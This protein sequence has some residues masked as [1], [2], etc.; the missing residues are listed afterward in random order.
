MLSRRSHMPIASSAASGH[1]CDGCIN[2]F[3]VTFSSEANIA[4]NLFFFRIFY[5]WIAERYK[6]VRVSFISLV[7]KFFWIHSGVLQLWNDDTEGCYSQN[8]NITLKWTPGKEHIKWYF[9]PKSAVLTKIL[10][11]SGVRRKLSHI[12]NFNNFFYFYKNTIKKLFCALANDGN[13]Y[14]DKLLSIPL[15]RVRL[16]LNSIKIQRTVLC[17]TFSA[18]RYR[19]TNTFA[20]TH[21][22][23]PSI[24]PW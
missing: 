20:W 13:V 14:W 10:G 8:L 6:S 17:Q 22:I 12:N 2:C 3:P 4:S 21:S 1:T 11:C 16:I 15:F 24:L 7:V 5:A 9:D 19:K 23:K 18:V